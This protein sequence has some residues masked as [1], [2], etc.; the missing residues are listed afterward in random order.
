[1]SHDRDTEEELLHP[2]DKWYYNLLSGQVSQ[3]PGPDRL[4]PYD[5]EEEAA[6]A[7]ELA[8]KR[9]EEWEEG[10]DEWNGKK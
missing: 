7:L 3:D 2:V 1:M 6:H 4:G 5:S 9:N 8:R 10:D